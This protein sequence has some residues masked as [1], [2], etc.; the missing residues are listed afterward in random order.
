MKSRL[1][2]RTEN[3]YFLTYTCCNE[4]RRVVCKPNPFAPPSCVNAPFRFFVSRKLLKNTPG[5]SILSNVSW[6]DAYE[7]RS[8]CKSRLFTDVDDSI[9]EES[10]E[11]LLIV[12]S[13]GVDLERWR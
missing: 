11:Y 13:G 4:I 6:L 10:G 7:S 2:S 8:R 3:S 12:K 5:L 1:P 9:E